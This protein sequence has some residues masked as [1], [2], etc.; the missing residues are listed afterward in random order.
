L[1][2]GVNPKDLHFWTSAQFPLGLTLLYEV[3]AVVASGWGLKSGWINL[4]DDLVQSWTDRIKALSELTS[5]S[6]PGGTSSYL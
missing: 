4:C 6:F 1:V 3:N 2:F 5:P